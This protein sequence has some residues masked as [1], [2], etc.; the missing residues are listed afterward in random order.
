MTRLVRAGS[1]DGTSQYLFPQV[2]QQI[3]NKNPHTQ[4]RWNEAV[5]AE[6]EGHE[7]LQLSGGAI[8]RLTGGFDASLESGV[9]PQD[10]NYIPPDAGEPA[11]GAV[12]SAMARRDE[13]LREA[14]IKI[15]DGLI[16]GSLTPLTIEGSQ[17]F[18]IT[19]HDWRR[20][21]PAAE[22]ADWHVHP[23]HIYFGNKRILVCFD[24][25]ETDRF[26][27]GSLHLPTI[28]KLPH[29]QRVVVEY[30]QRNFPSQ[31]YGHLG[32]L[33]GKILKEC[34][35]LDNSLDDKTFLAARTF[36]ESQSR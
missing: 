11:E 2:R 6:N 25:A 1:A 3:I 5:K 26:I 23:G 17:L 20:E 33:K 4:L 8:S 7:G 32:K 15:R 12:N 28:K 9:P 13:F 18:E 30:L 10:I 24:R 29:K 14:D 21:I 16:G 22:S 34:P 27:A 35:T 19:Y 36:I 31:D